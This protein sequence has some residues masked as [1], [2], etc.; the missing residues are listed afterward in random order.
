MNFRVTGSFD[1]LGAGAPREANADDL[2][3]E[4]KHVLQSAGRLPAE[5]PSPGATAP[6]PDPAATLSRT[7]EASLARGAADDLR[8][9]P[10]DPN[11]AAARAAGARASERRVGLRGR[12]LVAPVLGV[13]AALGAALLLMPSAPAPK[14]ANS[15]VLAEPQSVAKPPVLPP[16]ATSSD[17]VDPVV[18]NPA[19]APS[20]PLVA[21]PPAFGTNAVGVTTTLL[22]APAPPPAVASA[23]TG[24]EAI[25]PSPAP[26]QSVPAN[27]GATPVPAPSSRTTQSTSA[28]V[29][30]PSAKPAAETAARA[31]TAKA[32]VAKTDPAA[33]PA[34][35]KPPVAKTDAPTKPVAAMT[36]AKKKVVAKT[37]KAKAKT[38][39][40]AA[41][42][43]T[44]SK[45]APP[46]A[47]QPAAAPAPAAP[48]PPP[49]SFAAQSVGQVTNAFGYL[50]HLPGALMQRVTG[51]G[52]S[53]Q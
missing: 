14:R 4:L 7:I 9:G 34:A 29:S 47:V 38:D 22:N 52:A 50:T 44:S 2:L 41:S 25:P 6:E 15:V 53:A 37:E 48:A 3:A 24:A 27:A 1:R 49:P 17:V 40:I 45:P 43:A 30:A 26:V 21:E 28:I 19:S 8:A 39:A 11:A 5:A 16:V 20:A 35:A 13:V 12:K 31:E 42:S 10:R 23:P 18:K 36:P 32:V 46:P 33:K 51:S